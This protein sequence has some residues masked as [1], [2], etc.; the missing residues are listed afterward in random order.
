MKTYKITEDC[1]LSLRRIMVGDAIKVIA[2][3]KSLD[4]EEQTLLE[5]IESIFQNG[6]IDQL[7]RL[8]L[9]GDFPEG[10]VGEWLPLETALEV[11]EDFLASNKGLALRLK[12]LLARFESQIKELQ[13][14]SKV[15]TNP[16]E[17]TDTENS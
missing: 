16:E 4:R 2:I 3:F 9:A 8:T 7:A 5:F 1:T 17:T 10:K 15:D 14:S 12:P 11:A 13:P 6:L